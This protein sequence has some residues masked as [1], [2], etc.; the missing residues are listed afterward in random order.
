MPISTM[1][2]HALRTLWNS[3]LVQRM[4]L[5]EILEGAR[6]FVDSV[7]PGNSRL[8][9]T[10]VS[11]QAP[12]K[13]HLGSGNR[14]LSRD[15]LNTDLRPSPRVAFLDVTKP[16]PLPS[17]TFDYVY[18]EHMIEHIPF[19]KAQH[20]LRECLRVLRPGGRLRVATPDFEFLKQLQNPNLSELQRAYVAW[21]LPEKSVGPD[22]AGMFVLN[23]FFRSWGHRFIY[24]EATLRSSLRAAGFVE[25]ER[26]GLN[27]SGDAVLRGLENEARMPDGFLR[28]E[29]MVLEAVKPSAMFTGQTLFTRQS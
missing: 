8:I 15:W 9:K 1:S 24:D 12:R 27:Q 11:R 13:L 23:N 4:S 25:I 28:L 20:M 3:G 7:R 14:P 6:Q 5:P 17:G 10:A 22:A 19:D 26:Q 16:F 21:A 18:T 29:T 2:N